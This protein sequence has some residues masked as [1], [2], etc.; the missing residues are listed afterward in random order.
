MSD[1]FNYN[2]H[3]KIKLSPGAWHVIRKAA[4]G[5]PRQQIVE[6]GKVENSEIQEVIEVYE[7]KLAGYYV[8]Y[9]DPIIIELVF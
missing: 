3:I 8:K 2:K 6:I 5:V 1:Y 9:V 7:G 4:E